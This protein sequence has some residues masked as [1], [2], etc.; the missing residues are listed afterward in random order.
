MENN[1]NTF[2]YTYSAEQQAEIEKIRSKYM[3]KTD[4]KLE[5]LR[6]LDAS[7]TKKGTIIGIA[8][9]TVGCLIFGIAMSM[10]LVVGEM[11]IVLAI[12][13]G[14]PGI[15]A[16]AWAYPT[17]KKVTEKERERIAPQILALTEELGQ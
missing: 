17:Y 9:G 4:D 14:L 1:K 11:M 5:Q 2:E 13:V 6:K 3:P 7:V 10:A 16:M 8:L 12:I 15:A